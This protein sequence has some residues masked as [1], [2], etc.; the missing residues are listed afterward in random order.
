MSSVKHSHVLNFLILTLIFG[1]GCTIVPVPNLFYSKGNSSE[2]CCQ[3]KMVSRCENIGVNPSLLGEPSLL[4]NG[5][6]VH[7]LNV[8]PHNGFAYDTAWGDGVEAVFNYNEVTSNMFGHITTS[9]GQFAIEKCQEDHVWK[10]FHLLPQ[11]YNDE[12]SLKNK[13]LLKRIRS[14]FDNTTIVNISMMF[15]Y[16]DSFASVTPNIMDFFHHI[17]AKTNQGFINS[18]IP[19]RVQLH[20]IER[21]TIDDSTEGSILRRFS[22]MKTIE[23]LR[24]T[25]DGATLFGKY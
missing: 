18:K 14:G 25:A 5:G 3:D 20:C 7:L 10:E 6:N 13:P 8:L 23:D 1:I 4:V 21:A 2:V 19:L 24:N 22:R 17:I 16:T 12:V 11:D 15:Y 9:K